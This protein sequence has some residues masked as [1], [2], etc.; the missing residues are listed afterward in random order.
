[1]TR[2]EER[3]LQAE[4]ATAAEALSRE[5]AWLGWSRAQVGCL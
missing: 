3:A 4:G 1:M 5:Q 2:P